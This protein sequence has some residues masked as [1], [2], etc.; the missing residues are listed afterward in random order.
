MGKIA[1]NYR[2]NN[3]SSSRM[4]PVDMKFVNNNQDN[5]LIE[6]MTE[7]HPSGFSPKGVS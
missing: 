2:L 4:T 1:R 3:F 7:V 5:K 6:E